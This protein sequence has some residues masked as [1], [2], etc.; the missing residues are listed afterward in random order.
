VQL[1]GWDFL[2]GFQSR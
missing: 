2:I 1:A